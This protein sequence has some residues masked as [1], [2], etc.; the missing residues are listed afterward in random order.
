MTRLGYFGTDLEN[1][2]GNDLGFYMAR[3]LNSCVYGVDNCG[4]KKRRKEFVQACRWDQL[5]E[6]SFQW[7]GGGIR[8]MR[9]VYRDCGE[10]WVVVKIMV[11]FGIPIIIRHLIF[12]VP[13]K[14]P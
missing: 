6:G 12:W 7:E 1:A 5:Q 3:A 9:R 8:G 4:P 14:G 2:A 13:K 10:I 11:P